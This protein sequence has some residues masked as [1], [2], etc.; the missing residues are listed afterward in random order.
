MTPVSNA[1]VTKTYEYS[2]IRIRCLFW[3]HKNPIDLK[4]SSNSLSNIALLLCVSILTY[5]L[6]SA[7]MEAI[8]TC[9]VE[10]LVCILYNCVAAHKTDTIRAI[11][12]DM[13]HADR[14]TGQKYL[15]VQ[16]KQLHWKH[17]LPTRARD[18][19]HRDCS[20][21]LRYIAIPQ[22]MATSQLTE[23]VV[24]GSTSR[25]AEWH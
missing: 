21:A 9:L 15:P 20:H 17:G 8:S 5:I 19:M 2:S 6:K 11:Y 13:N 10:L 22:E 7:Q 23:C 25:S 1:V 3:I 16:A 24:Q 4:R 14:N 18:F 12:N